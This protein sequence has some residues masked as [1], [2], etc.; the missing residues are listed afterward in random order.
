M[1]TIHILIHSRPDVFHDKCVCVGSKGWVYLRKGGGGLHEKG[2]V[3][4]LANSIFQ[5]LVN[6]WK[7]YKT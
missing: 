2:T 7:G 1:Y 5:Y 3:Q 4:I 6:F